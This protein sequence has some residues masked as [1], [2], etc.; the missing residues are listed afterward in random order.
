ME[1]STVD[2]RQL[3]AFAR[4]VREGSFSRAARALDMVLSSAG[5]MRRLLPPYLGRGPRSCARCAG[6]TD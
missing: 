5:G 4:I 2:T 1:R 6:L 3:A